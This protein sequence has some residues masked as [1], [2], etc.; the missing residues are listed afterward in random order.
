MDNIVKDLILATLTEN[1]ENPLIETIVRLSNACLTSSKVSEICDLLAKL[2]VQC[3]IG[4]AQKVYAGR[5]G[6]YNVL[7]DIYD[8]FEPDCTVTLPVLD[9]LISLMDGQPDLLDDRGVGFMLRLLEESIELGTQRRV[10]QWVRICCIKHEN[11]RQL[12][13]NSKIFPIL[14]RMLENGISSS[15]LVR[16]VC[17]VIRALVLDDDIRVEYG[18]A[19]HHAANMGA[20]VLKTITD[21]L[22][23]E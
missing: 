15:L 19:Y 5:H 10:L 16:S 13:F 21:L 8:K 18:N 2:Q 17:D 1:A 14:K 23:R 6:A 22:K 7:L 4:L 9:N 12:I 11:N 20:E 3:D